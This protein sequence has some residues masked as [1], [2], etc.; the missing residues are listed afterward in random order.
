MLSAIRETYQQQRKFLSFKQLDLITT[1]DEF[2]SS[3]VDTWAGSRF[4]I[5][6]LQEFSSPPPTPRYQPHTLPSAHFLLIP[7][8]RR[9]C[10]PSLPSSAPTT[11][12]QHPTHHTR[13]RPTSLPP[14]PTASYKKWNV[15]YFYFGNHRLDTVFVVL[16]L[17]QDI[18]NTL[19]IA[20][21]ITLFNIVACVKVLCESF[22]DIL[23][24]ASKIWTRCVAIAIVLCWWFSCIQ[25][26]LQQI[27]GSVGQMRCVLGV[28]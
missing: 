3:I 18:T 14:P 23:I 2:I 28:Q 27:C 22:F 7:H 24:Q 26:C 20:T 10:M 4:G 17:A 12:P 6:Q 15:L 9:S 1:V 8:L 5:I 19:T 13:H 16:S 25:P 11:S 21:R